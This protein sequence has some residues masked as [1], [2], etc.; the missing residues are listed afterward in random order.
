MNDSILMN[1]LRVLRAKLDMS[2]EE[3]AEKTGVTRVTINNIENRKWVPSTVLALKIAGIFRVSL[4][5]VF[6]LTEDKSN[7]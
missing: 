1:N 2:Q 3:L 6:W 4:E 7:L 5:E